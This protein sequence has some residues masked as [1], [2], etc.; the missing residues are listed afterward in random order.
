MPCSRARVSRT[1]WFV[2]TVR[3]ADR[4]AGRS[5]V[6]GLRRE[7]SF[8]R[9]SARAQPGVNRVVAR[10]QPPAAGDRRVAP[11]HAGAGRAGEP[12]AVGVPGGGDR[13]PGKAGKAWC[14]A[15]R[16]LLR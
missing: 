5:L 6:A 10:S 15:W 11:V 1:S 9:R 14:T 13:M 7:E 4:R 3:D 16:L 8:G 2:S 12:V